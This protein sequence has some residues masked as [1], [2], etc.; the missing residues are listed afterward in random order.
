MIYFPV[1]SVY[2]NNI[3]LRTI[4]ILEIN[5]QELTKIV[6]SVLVPNTCVCDICKDMK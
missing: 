5:F 6:G 4:K 2:G 3:C 1:L